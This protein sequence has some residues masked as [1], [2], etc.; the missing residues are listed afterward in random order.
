MKPYVQ[1]H[2]KTD[3]PDWYLAYTRSMGYE[4]PDY[5]KLDKQLGLYKKLSSLN[6]AVSVISTIGAPVKQQV[7]E[8][9]GEEKKNIPNHPLEVRLEF[10]NPIN[11][12]YAFMRN[13][14][15]YLVMGR[16]YWWLNATAPNAEPS[17]LWLIPSNKIGPIGDGNLGI[18]HYLYDPGDG[19]LLEIPPEQIIMFG[20]D[21][22]L[23]PLKSF[24]KIETI[25]G[26]AEGDLN[27]QSYNAKLFKGNGRLPGVMAFADNIQDDEWEDIKEQV[28]RNAANQNILLLRNVGSGQMKWEQGGT[29]PK[30]LEFVE[31]RIHNRNEIWNTFAQGLVSML[32]ENATE[33]NARSGKAT[34]I[35]LVVYPLLQYIGSEIT[36]HLL[37][38]YGEGLI[39]EP[40]DIRV[41]DR[42][43]EIQE[44]A[45]YSKTHT[46]D[47]VRKRY[48]NDK[49]IENEEVG[50]LLVAAAQTAGKAEPE[51]DTPGDGL[52][53]ETANPLTD[54]QTQK[55]QA[56][57]KAQVKDPRPAMLELDKWERKAVK[58]LGKPFDFECYNVPLRMAEAIKADLALCA[59]AEAVKTI[60]NRARDEL[61]IDA[62]METTPTT[63][64]A[65][66]LE[67]I[68]L[69][70]T[71]V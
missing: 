67:G 18:K 36:S 25:A 59:N 38:R 54:I 9:Q 46:V 64:A 57:Q 13:T 37:P 23:S 28:D 55:E 48:W 62:P 31:G 19:R 56:A 16:A 4:F 8:R 33:A 39:C 61:T 34:L 24:S 52:P 68:R 63:D 22:L 32:S 65:A 70:L 5:S 42:I 66:V 71:K 15:R 45:E 50:G 30:E 49:P 60:F 35:D 11:S 10:P 17:E 51:E 2:K 26:I 69:A 27:M 7:K 1:A 43:L 44:I 3:Y 20:E 40:E 6:T 14:L 53:T 21:D 29:S 58:N 47:E 12:G 41:T